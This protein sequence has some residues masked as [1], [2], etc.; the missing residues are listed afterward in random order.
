MATKGSV[1]IIHVDFK[2]HKLEKRAL[3]LRHKA[4]S[5]PRKPFREYASNYLLSLAKTNL[6]NDVELLKETDKATEVFQSDAKLD[7]FSQEDI[8]AYL[9]RKRETTSKVEHVDDE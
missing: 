4:S 1:R 9:A 6:A 8:E 3:F 5:E 2:D 7:R